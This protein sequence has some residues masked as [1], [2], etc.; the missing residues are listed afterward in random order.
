MARKTRSINRTAKT[1]EKAPLKTK[2][3]TLS[4]E[5]VTTLSVR[6]GA[7]TPFSTQKVE[8]GMTHQIMASQDASAELD[9]IKDMLKGKLDAYVEENFDDEEVESSD[10]SAADASEDEEFDDADE[11]EDFADE[12][13]D[14]DDD[15]EDDDGGFSEEEINKMKRPELLKL[16]EDEELDVDPDAFK[17]ISELREAVMDEYFGDEDDDDEDAGDEEDEDDFDNFDDD[18]E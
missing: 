13:E 7:S 3:E 2:V 15:A 16:I 18:D 12:G 17:K 6:I 1:Q 5:L 14:E 9:K 4:T 8:F 11:D 10:E